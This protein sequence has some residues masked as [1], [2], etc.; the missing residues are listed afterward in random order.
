METLE[1]ILQMLILRFS[2]FTAIRSLSHLFC[3]DTWLCVDTEAAVAEPGEQ[4]AEGKTK[5][6]CRVKDVA[7]MVIVRSKDRITAGDGARAHDMVGK[8]VIST[9]T[10]CSVFELLNKAGEIMC[11]LCNEQHVFRLMLCFIA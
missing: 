9:S 1:V 3:D 11:V 4:I 7:G 2:E 5:V 6:I 10:N 8:S